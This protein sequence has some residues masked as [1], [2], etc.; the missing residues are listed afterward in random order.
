MLA[1]TQAT[2]EIPRSAGPD[3]MNVGT[4]T[5]TAAMAVTRSIDDSASSPPERASSMRAASNATA[6]P[7]RT[8]RAPAP[9][10]GPK[11]L[12]ATSTS[13]RPRLPQRKPAPI[14]AMAQAIP[15]GAPTSDLTVKTPATIH[16]NPA[17]TPRRPTPHAARPAAAS[18]DLEAKGVKGARGCC[19]AAARAA[20]NSPHGGYSGDLTPD[21]CRVR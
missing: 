18:A 11:S 6:I 5:T 1:P 9:S 16:T 3:T 7:A 14:H 2:A 10:V 13:V 4:N 21:W 20:G 12:V 8:A 19:A 17:S 15:G